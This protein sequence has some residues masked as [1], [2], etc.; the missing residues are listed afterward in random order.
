MKLFFFFL[1]ILLV[2]F[3]QETQHLPDLPETIYPCILFFLVEW[4]DIFSKNLIAFFSLL[5]R[6]VFSYLAHCT[7]HNF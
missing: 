4:C 6:L 5:L 2:S 1:E 3:K 7:L